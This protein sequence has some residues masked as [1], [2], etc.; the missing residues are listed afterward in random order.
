M[1]PLSLLDTVIV[2]VYLLLVSGVGL[3][4]LRKNKTA[5]D[6]YVG[7]RRCGTFTLGCLWMASWIGGATVIGSVDKAYAIGVSALWYCGAMALGCVI[8]AL[9]STGLIQRVGARFSCLTYPEII[10]LRYGPASRLLATCSTFLAY[11]A[12]AAGQFLAQ[13]KLLEG[14]LGWD[15]SL[16]LWVSAASMIVY[17]GLGGFVAVAI[18]G[19]GQALLILVALVFVM[20]PVMAYSVTHTPELAAI[21][22]QFF[23]PS[24]WGWGKV[25]GLVVTIVL[26]FYTSMD[27]YTRCFASKSMQAAKRGTLLAALFVAVI[28]VATTFIGMSG[29]ALSSNALQSGSVMSSLI[30]QF[31]PPG[32]KGFVLIGLLAA[33]M[34]TGSVC[35]LVASANITQDIGKRFVW[36]GMGNRAAR[37]I[38]AASTVLVGFLAVYLSLARQDIIDVLYIAFT[39]NSAG[40]FIPTI[41]TFLWKRGGAGTAAWSMAAS[42]A[43]VLFWYVAQTLWPENTLFALDPVWPGLLVSAVVYGTGAVLVPLTTAEQNKVVTLHNSYAGKEDALLR[44]TAR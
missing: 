21:P 22:M 38:G 4:A 40:L 10:E 8:F 26:T 42:L 28:A 33:I 18:T 34:S 29:R 23:D 7:G 12:Y 32:L 5:D 30:M 35:L 3:Y 9:T 37:L 41:G 20:M 14:F 11:I 6:Y 24:A 31:M 27:S 15:L 19:V 44:S 25:L 43:V 13:A 1:I 39:L 36:P 17:T 16:S 2:V